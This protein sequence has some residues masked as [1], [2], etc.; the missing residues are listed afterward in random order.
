M[1]R[2][3]RIALLEAECA[4]L[5]NEIERLRA[6]VDG[7]EVRD[8]GSVHIREQASKPPADATV[9]HDSPSSDKIA[10]FRSLFRGR[11]D[12]YPIRWESKAGRSGYRPACSNEWVHGICEKPRIKCADCPHQAFVPISDNAVYEHLAGR[13]TVGVYPLLH[14]DTTWFIAADFDGSPWHND[15]AAYAAS[16]RELGVPA[17]TEISRSGEGAHVWIFFSSAIPAS[18][19]R[20]LASAA[21]TRACARHRMLALASNDRL[22]P[23]QDTMPKGASAT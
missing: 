22:F 11:E 1:A 9:R 4:R 5:Q 20:N 12:V 14:D 15:A 2:N 8:G 3:D 16:C 10:L 7:R 17:Y 6:I 21:L 23:S 18:Q 13:R 19:A